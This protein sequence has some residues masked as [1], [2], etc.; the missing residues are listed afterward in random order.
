MLKRRSDV[1]YAYLPE[2]SVIRLIPG[3]TGMID[4][5]DV[6]PNGDMIWYRGGSRIHYLTFEIAGAYIDSQDSSELRYDDHGSVV[7]LRLELAYLN[8]QQGL[9]LKV[10]IFFRRGLDGNILETEMVEDASALNIEFQFIYLNNFQTKLGYTAF[11]DGGENH[12][13]TDRDNVSINFSYSF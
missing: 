13:I 8:I 6:R 11:F 9:D 10:P 3:C 12:L 2:Q 7:N 4:H 5:V 1:R